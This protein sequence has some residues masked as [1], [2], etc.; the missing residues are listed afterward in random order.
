[1]I[2]KSKS[3]FHGSNIGQ[4]VLISFIAFKYVEKKSH[5]VILNYFGYLE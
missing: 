5:L 4:T 2:E 3:F 1:M